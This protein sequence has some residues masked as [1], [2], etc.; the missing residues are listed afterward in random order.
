MPQLQLEGAVDDRDL[1]I[2]GLREKVRGLEEQLT[3]ERSRNVAVDQGMKKLRTVLQP[4]HNAL[5]MIFGEMGSMGVESGEDATPSPLDSRKTAVWTS[6]KQKFP[7][8]PAKFIDALLLYGALTQSQLRI[9]AQCAKG[10]V[11]GVVSQLYKAGLI[12]K[13][14]GKISLKEV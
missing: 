9:H 14:G 4:L 7:G 10:S 11:P 5:G 2:S 12:S 8:I 6:W 3:D 1:I 13:N